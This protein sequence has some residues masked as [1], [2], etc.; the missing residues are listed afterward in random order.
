[1][2]DAIY[3]ERYTTYQNT[4]MQRQKKFMTETHSNSSSSY[5]KL[6]N[7]ALLWIFLALVVLLYGLSFIRVQRHEWSIALNKQA[8]IEEKKKKSLVTKD[9][10][11][12]SA[13]TKNP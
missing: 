4:T 12:I 11:P 1:M 3:F 6:R 2:H 13:S 9:R 10:S 8:T 5:L 7:K